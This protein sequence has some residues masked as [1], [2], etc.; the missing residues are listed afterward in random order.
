MEWPLI[1]DF[2]PGGGGIVQYFLKRENVLK[3][4]WKGWHY[5]YALWEI[6]L[7]LIGMSNW[8]DIQTPICMFKILFSHWL[9]LYWNTKDDK[10]LT[11]FN[12]LLSEILRQGYALYVAVHK[13]VNIIRRCGRIKGSIVPAWDILRER[14]FIASDGVQI[15]NYVETSWTA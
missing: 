2:S 6:L 7:I 15:E 14:W 8:A 10:N 13:T 4:S 3:I 12:P 5:R 1:M 11:K 9:L